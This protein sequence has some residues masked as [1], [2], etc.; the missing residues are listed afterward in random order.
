MVGVGSN[1]D[2]AQLLLLSLLSM[3]RLNSEDRGV[4]Y[5]NLRNSDLAPRL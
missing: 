1:P 2:G 5:E 3:I 4:A